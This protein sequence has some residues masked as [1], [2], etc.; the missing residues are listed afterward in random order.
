LNGLSLLEE[1]C[2][3]RPNQPKRTASLACS[4]GHAALAFFNFPFTWL[5]NPLELRG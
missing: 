3:L 1:E 4:K 5:E 2:D